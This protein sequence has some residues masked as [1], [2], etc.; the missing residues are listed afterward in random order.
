MQNTEERA[1][2]EVEREIKAYHRKK[3]RD[4]LREQG[5]RYREKK[6]A[7]PEP[8]SN[9]AEV[10]TIYHAGRKLCAACYMYERRAGKRRQVDPSKSLSERLKEAQRRRQVEERGWAWTPER[11]AELRRQLEAGASKRSLARK[12][13]VS[14]STICCYANYDSTTEMRAARRQKQTG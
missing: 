3:H 10:K 2:V 1:P 7:N 5:A 11:I 9:C 4:T 6:R 13:G 14:T 8:C 12:Y